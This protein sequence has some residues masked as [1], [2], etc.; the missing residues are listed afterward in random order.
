MQF[1]VRS[2]RALSSGSSGTMYSV[3]RE[4]PAFVHVRRVACAKPRWIV[5][6]VNKHQCVQYSSAGALVRAHTTGA[7]ISAICSFVLS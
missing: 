2:L 4:W 3:P 5:Q 7:C 1:C 6:S